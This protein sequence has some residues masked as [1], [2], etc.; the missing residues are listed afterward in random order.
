MGLA[1]KLTGRAIINRFKQ[2]PWWCSGKEST[3]QCRGHESIVVQEDSTCQ[4]A[5]EP[6]RSNY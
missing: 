3:H 5:T 1:H 6:E 4:G 2:H